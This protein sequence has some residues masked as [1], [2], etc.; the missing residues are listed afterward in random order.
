MKIGIKVNAATH[1]KVRLIK[2]FRACVKVG[3]KEAKEIV[4]M[5]MTDAGHEVEV[6]NEA[7]IS[8]LIDAGFAID[9]DPMQHPKELLRRAALVELDNG[10]F[11]QA[12]SI[13]EVL[14]NYY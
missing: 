9:Y 14:K 5:A 1:D 2:A 10:N 12:N 4:E 8:E 13:T 11:H 3:L 7:V 6:E